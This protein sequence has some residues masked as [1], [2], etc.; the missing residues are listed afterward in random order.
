[1]RQVFTH[2]LRHFGAAIAALLLLASITAYG[3]SLGDVAREN[4]ENK[5]QVSA[6]APP[7][8]I[9]DADLAQDAQPPSESGASTKPQTAPPDKPGAARRSAATPVDPRVAEQWRNQILAQK[10][11]VT[12]LEKRVARFQASL[13]YGDSS[14]IARGEILTRNQALEQQRLAQAQEQLEEQKARLLE[15]QDEARRAGMYPKV[16]DP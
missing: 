11:T 4:R 9:T 12:A 14:A 7:R 5:A 13:S 3:Q 8:V 2:H 6:T 1:M 16:F 10:R 15:M